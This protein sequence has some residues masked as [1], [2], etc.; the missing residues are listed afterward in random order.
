MKRWDPHFTLMFLS[1]NFPVPGPDTRRIIEACSNVELP[2]RSK[3]MERS[4]PT[5]G[6]NVLRERTYFHLEES[7]TTSRR[8][9][10]LV[11]N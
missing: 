6:T 2:R 1:L 9:W 3:E 4:V 5:G 10:P 7:G 11:E 8:R